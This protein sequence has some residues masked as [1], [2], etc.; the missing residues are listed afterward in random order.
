ME[1]EDHRS[2]M[3]VKAYKIERWEIPTFTNA[4]K[5]FFNAITVNNDFAFK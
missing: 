5:K 2:E 3:S 1:V 4:S